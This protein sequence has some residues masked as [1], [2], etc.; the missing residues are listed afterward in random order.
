M[1]SPVLLASRDVHGVAATALVVVPVE[2]GLPRIAW[3]GVAREG[4]SAAEIA[5]SVGVSGAA[6][7]TRH[8]TGRSVAVLPE[9]SQAWRGT[10]GLAGFRLGDETPGAGWSTAF[11]ATAVTGTD[12]ALTIE[13]VDDAAQLT[14]STEVQAVAGGGLRLRHTLTNAGGSRYAIEALDV[15]VP[16]AEYVAEALDFT[17]RHC[18]ERVPQRHRIGDGTWLRAGH[19]GKPGADSPTMLVAGTEGF[20]FGHGEVWALHV[21][22]SGNS[23]YYLERQSSGVTVLGGGEALLPGEVV[24]ASGESYATPWVHFGASVDG[25]DSLAA[26]V[27]E[28]LRAEPAHPTSPRPVN[29]NV[30]EAVYFDHDLAQLKAVADRAAT[31]G[32][33]RFVLDDGWFGARRDDHAGLGDWTVSANA[34]PDGLAP[35][36]DHVHGA[37]MQFGLWFEPEMVNPDSDLYRAHPDWIL[38]TGDRV[39]ATSRNQLVLDFGRADVRAHLVK[40]VDR[41]LSEYQIDYVKW[42]HNRDLVDAGSTP[43]GG[44]AGVHEAT[45]GFYAV[46]DELRRR[47][48]SVEWESCAAG[49][50]R[51]DLGVLTRV[52]RVWTSDMTDALSRQAI[53]RWTQQLVPP[54]YLG[55]HICAP[56]NHQTGRTLPLDFRVGTAFFGDFGFEWDLTDATADELT[57]LAEWVGLYK[58]HRDL[59]H[60]GRVVRVDSPSTAVWQHAVVAHDRGA[61]V[62]GYAQL[63]FASSDPPPWRVP[64]LDPQRRYRVS[65]VSPVPAGDWRGAGLELSGA[66]L[67]D[68]GLSAPA[69]A[70]QSVTIAHL[71]ARS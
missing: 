69:R 10:P 51:I 71:H 42:D 3:T 28:Y 67:R 29:L 64:G 34:W 54:E 68:V 53:Q 18:L 15:V 21:A 26:Q 52:Q 7:G 55:A 38:A 14:L 41:V 22:W 12:S 58:T 6:L 1:S 46:L 33:E 49:G 65:L 35:L 17:G 24:L 56:V 4:L 62:A 50:G 37:G 32:V 31:V 8:V 2:D 39:P 9:P 20:G 63:D 44:A 36:I 5:V 27:H 60:S 40:Q 48:P 59:L 57:R 45:L 66:A 61:A 13:A 70:P 19:S 47:H 43:R 25:L 30:W 16:V 11:R 23:R